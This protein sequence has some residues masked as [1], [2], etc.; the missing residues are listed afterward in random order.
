MVGKPAREGR[1]LQKDI[2]GSP[3]PEHNFSIIIETVGD[4]GK[5]QFKSFFTYILKYIE[6]NCS[7]YVQLP[8]KFQKA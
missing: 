1:S 3:G 5:P 7:P 4:Q 8:Q 6:Y 2:N